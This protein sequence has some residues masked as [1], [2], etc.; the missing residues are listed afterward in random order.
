MQ[1]KIKIG[2]VGCGRVA[3]HYG[4]F[5]S[6]NLVKN[7]K[8]KFCCDLNLEKSKN[9]KKILKTNYGT[10]FKKLV[11]KYIEVCVFSSLLV[12]LQI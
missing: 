10:S 2:I 4:Y 11:T 8:I 1:K 7:F 3:Q 12:T 6:K 9:L 5:F